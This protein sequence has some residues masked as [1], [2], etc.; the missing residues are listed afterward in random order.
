MSQA[1]ETPKQEEKTSKVDQQTDWLDPPVDPP[2]KKG[3]YG[4]FRERW[5][6]FVTNLLDG[7]IRLFPRGK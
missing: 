7:L 6:T 3:L 1:N 5:R 2:E 4:R